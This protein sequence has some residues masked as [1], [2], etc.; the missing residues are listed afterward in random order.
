MLNRIK[1][2]L[3]SRVCKNIAGTGIGCEITGNKHISRRKRAFHF[4]LLFKLC[5]TG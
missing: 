1:I 5:V 2:V 4:K 3:Y